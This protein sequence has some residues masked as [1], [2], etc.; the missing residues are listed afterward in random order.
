M[1]MWTRNLKFWPLCVSTSFTRHFRH[2][3]ISSTYTKMDELIVYGNPGSRGNGGAL[4]FRKAPFVGR[5]SIPKIDFDG[6][7]HT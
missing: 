7:T 4:K 1:L 3:A 2:R 6:L 5:C